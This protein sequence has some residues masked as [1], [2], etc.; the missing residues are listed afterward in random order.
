MSEAMNPG[1]SRVLVTGAGGFIGQHL[2]Q[3]LEQKGYEV[4]ALL[5]RQPISG[6]SA[7]ADSNNHI[8]DINDTE[9]LERALEG[10]ELVFHLAGMAH[11]EG[12][13]PSAL[14]SVNTDGTA[15]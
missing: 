10:V 8:G 2:C 11:V 5:G 3:Q 14:Q 12:S 4:V 9:L 13:D 1:S 15:S 7:V 6:P